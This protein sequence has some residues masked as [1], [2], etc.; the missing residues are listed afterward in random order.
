M[1]D[2]NGNKTYLT[3]GET[4]DQVQVMTAE[5]GATKL[6]PFHVTDDL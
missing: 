6:Y 1:A 2:P 5:A 4:Y 3:A